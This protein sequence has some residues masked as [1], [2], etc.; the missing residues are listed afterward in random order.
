MATT[1]DELDAVVQAAVSLS[2]VSSK[3]GV[4]PKTRPPKP[5][6]VEDSAQG[7]DV[8]SAQ[9]DQDDGSDSE[10]T[11]A[12]NTPQLGPQLEPEEASQQS[13]SDDSSISTTK[14]SRRGASD[15][16]K[17]RYM[18]LQVLLQW[19]PDA[20]E[21]LFCFKPRPDLEIQA[22]LVPKTESA[23][24]GTG[25][26]LKCLPHEELHY[27]TN[28]SCSGNKCYAPTSFLGVH[29]QRS[30]VGSWK[31]F[32]RVRRP[33]DAPNTPFETLPLI[34]DMVNLRAPAA[35]ESVSSESDGEERQRPTPAKTVVLSGI[36]SLTNAKRRKRT[37]VESAKT[38]SP[39]GESDEDTTDEER[40]VV[41]ARAKRR[42]LSTKPVTPLR[43]RRLIGPPKDNFAAVP[44][45]VVL[46]QYVLVAVRASPSSLYTEL[47]TK[48][49][50]LFKHEWQK[51]TAC[52][53]IGNLVKFQMWVASHATHLMN[54]AP[55]LLLSSQESVQDFDGFV[56]WMNH[57]REWSKESRDFSMS[58][59]QTAFV[60]RI[61]T[62]EDDLRSLQFRTMF[63]SLRKISSDLKFALRKSRT[64]PVGWCAG[65][66]GDPL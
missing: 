49:D 63:N 40:A 22:R 31:R 37:L 29:R 14:L 61:A 23:P 60:E 33:E 8:T 5:V 7:D 52:A 59:E 6:H 18:T 30:T 58:T 25:Y 36:G 28:K 56:E 3:R 34:D 42:R 53:A 17:G 2:R 50:S 64:A 66:G 57:F 44:D 1:T 32:L 62:Y 21:W 13:D 27:G 12:P 26:T 19:F 48:G 55:S 46:Q 65:T 35:P 51:E 54:M 41:P 45:I 9:P 43:V 4:P 11:T 15:F 16:A 10:A 47:E 38:D 20:T 39:T 24:R